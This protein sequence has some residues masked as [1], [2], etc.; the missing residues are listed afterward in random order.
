MQRALRDFAAGGIFIACGLAFAIMA[1]GY[2]LGTPVRMGPG[3]FPLALGCLLAALGVAVVAK[4]VLAGE[5]EAI[6]VIP[7][8][9]LLLILGAVLVFGLTVRGLG[10]AAALFI[11]IAMSAFASR[12]T[13]PAV[14]LALAVLLTAFC[15]LIFV[16]GLGLPLALF[17][18]W[19][20]F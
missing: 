2:D 3:T 12:R 20:P 17:G 14:A 18:P 7:W 8:R 9:A 13:S 15:A 4:G 10:L 11:S 6:G 1:Y 5:G 16:F 19:L